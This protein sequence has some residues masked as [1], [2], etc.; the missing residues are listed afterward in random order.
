MA[1]LF[2][3]EDLE[4]FY[5]AEN[6]NIYEKM[7]AHPVCENGTDGVH[8]AVWAPHAISVSVIC[9]R[10]GWN[11]DAGRLHEKNG[12]WQGFVAGMQQGESYRY[13]VIGADHV[14]RYKSDPYGTMSELRPANASVVYDIGGYEW[15]D[16]EWQSNKGADG[17]YSGP[18]SV[19]E[20]HLGSWKKD[21]YRGE[22][23]FLNYTEI[24]DQL[25]EYVKYMGYTHI[26]LIGICEY[27]FDGS[28][29]YQVTGYYAPTS[30]YGTPHDFMRFVDTMHKNGIGVIL[31]WVPAHFPKDAHGLMLFDGTPLYEYAD[32]LRSDYVDWGTKAFD[33]GRNEVCNFLIGSALMWVEKYHIDAIRTDAV[34]AMLYS[35]FGREKWYVNKDGGC[36]N[37]E[38][39]AFLKKLNSVI[40]ERTHA[41]V[42]AEDSSIYDG[43]TRP[44]GEG[45]LGFRYKW[46]L[47]WMNDTLKYIEKDPIY[48][49]FHHGEMTHTIDYAFTE[50]FMLV[51][52]HDEVVHLKKPMLYKC[53]G[54][55]MDKCGC[56][57]TLYTHMIGHPGKKLLF[58]GQDFGQTTEWD[59]KRMIDW[60][61]VDKPEHRDIMENVRALLHIYRTHP[62]LYTDSDN[63]NIF[64]WI[65]ADDSDRSIF[66]YMR[67]NPW[68]YNDALI[69][70]CNFTPVEYPQYSVGVPVRGRYKRI[71]STYGI[72]G[73][74]VMRAEKGLCDGFSDH[75]SFPLRA[76]ESVI[77]EVPRNGRK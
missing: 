3:A 28:W 30:R 45:G 54:N 49:K 18:M 77:I 19:Y 67:R 69:F 16:A 59:E 35:S 76:Y 41:Y 14:T 61:L 31:D 7:G 71:Y 57:K 46:S 50:H 42:I 52:S 13:R 43:V 6:Y 33:L 70:V 36:E 25:A 1:D 44:V 32:P 58:M 23:G 15:D 27:P 73:V 4:L 56:L 68:N 74:D 2:T 8:F 5:R 48:R 62:V 20:V 40:T 64:S 75:V 39:I 12:V 26:E 72:D 55:M 63:P 51:L 53:P 29:G 21:Y 38:S 24:A 17:S 37:Y 66:S 10:N 22:D 9:E 65:R 47:G 34:A 60:Y 11:G